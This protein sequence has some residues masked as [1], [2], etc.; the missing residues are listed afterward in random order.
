[1][2]HNWCNLQQHMYVIFTLQDILQEYTGVLW[3]DSSVR[4]VK[5]FTNL[6]PLH[7]LT[8]PNNGAVLFSK[9]G[10]SN[11]AVTN[12]GMYKY[13]GTNL[14]AQKTTNTFQAGFALYYRT[15]HT[16]ENILKWYVVCALEPECIAPK[17]SQLYCRFRGL[18]LYANC[19]RYDQS[20]INI[21]MSNFYHFNS[22][23]YTSSIKFYTISRRAENNINKL[24]YCSNNTHLKH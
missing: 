23:L 19:H 17:G 10:H 24:K 3:M 5:P 22:S 16:I 6:I 11:L 12:P 13:I 18:S 21:I 2:P 9:V 4:F 20:L 15:R 7:Q 14:T 8:Y 1:M